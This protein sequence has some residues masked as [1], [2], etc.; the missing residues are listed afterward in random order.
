MNKKNFRPVPVHPDPEIRISGF[1]D[2]QEA[3]T[4]AK[5]RFRIFLTPNSLITI[6]NPP[7]KTLKTE[8][9]DI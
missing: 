9:L 2:F 7:E 1:S 5:N 3:F 4:R 8:K 6:Q